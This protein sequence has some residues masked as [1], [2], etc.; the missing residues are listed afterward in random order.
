M[1]INTYKQQQLFN[2]VKQFN[3]IKLIMNRTIIWALSNPVIQLLI[4]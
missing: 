2:T 4:H 1:N 3:D